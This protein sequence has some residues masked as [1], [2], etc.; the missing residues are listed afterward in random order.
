VTLPV[1]APGGAY[2]R[3]RQ[4]LK[5]SG[6][7]LAV[8]PQTLGRWFPTG[9]QR[10]APCPGR[11]GVAARCHARPAA[12]FLRQCGAAKSKRVGEPHGATGVSA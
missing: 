10:G 3:K 6:S 12:L 4:R 1:V 11:N 7:R 8:S 5:Q 9:M 2:A